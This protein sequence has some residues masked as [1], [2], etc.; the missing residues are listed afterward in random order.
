M[1]FRIRVLEALRSI[2][3]AKREVFEGDQHA[4]K[5]V[6]DKI[7][8]GFRKNI[9][10]TDPAQIEEAIILANDS[11]KFLRCSVVQL[12][13]KDKDTFELRLTKNTITEKNVPYD[14]TKEVHLKPKRKKCSPET[15]P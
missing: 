8:E 3:R 14:P 5:V 10:L 1:A 13:Q 6:T 2:H 12:R 9:H 11:A 7:R 15:E 4:L